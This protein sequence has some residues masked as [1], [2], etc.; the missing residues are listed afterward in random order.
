MPKISVIIPVYNVEEY[1]E[2]CLNSVMNQSF[3][4]YEVIVVDDGTRDQSIEKIKDY[5]VK[6]IHQKNAGLSAAR[7]RGVREAS[8]DYLLFLDSDDYLEKDLFKRFSQSLKNDPDLVRF[9]IQEVYSDHTIIPYQE[10]GFM[11]C[12]GV[13]AFSKI[14][15]Y[16][17][18]E[19]AWCYFIKRQYY[20]KN[21]FQFK[22]G[23]IHEDYGLIPLIIMKAKVVNSIDYIGYNYVQRD[24]S[25]MS[26]VDYQK[27]KK[28]VNDF[29]LHYLFLINEIDKTELDSTIFKSFAANSLILKVCELEGED[30]Q[31]FK[32][33]LRK[34]HVFDCLLTDTLIRKI[35]K[36][37][38]QLSPKLGKKLLK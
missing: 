17:F 20:T 8:G 37:I 30:Y 32:K 25:I 3:K 9:Q 18:V 24:N 22:E 35:K 1:I 27:T 12:S 21:H 34:D 11:N 5:P 16:H 13:D 14:C 10:K 38:F 23:T 6:I 28:K 2:K 15:N 19:N 29:Y 31:I 33:R 7:N 26:N 4:D 36:I